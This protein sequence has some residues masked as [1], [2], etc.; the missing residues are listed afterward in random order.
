MAKGVTVCIGL[1]GEVIEIM[2]GQPELAQVNV[3]GARR[4]ISI[5]LLTDD[6]P[7]PGDRV[8]IKIDTAL[9]ELS[10]DQDAFLPTA[11]AAEQLHRGQDVLDLVVNSLFRVGLRLQAAIDLSQEQAGQR[12]TDALRCLDDAIREIRDH[13]FAGLGH[14]G[15]PGPVPPSGTG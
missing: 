15:L 11:A 10:T 7:R 6:P 5:T 2:P 9:S 14:D 3:A 13:A 12:I 1:S 4:L 8:L